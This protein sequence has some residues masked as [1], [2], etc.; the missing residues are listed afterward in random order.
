M[1]I[2]QNEKKYLISELEKLN[3]FEWDDNLFNKSKAVQIKDFNKV[4]HITNNLKNE[5]QIK[6]CSMIYTFSKP[7]YFRNNELCLIL[8]QENH[9]AEEAFINFNVYKVSDTHI[10]TEEYA[11]I[12]FIYKN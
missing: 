7:T 12:F 1:K 5:E 6:M 4:F 8:Y 3:H 11:S 2:T 10:P 9:S